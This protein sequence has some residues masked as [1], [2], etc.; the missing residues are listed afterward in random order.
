MSDQQVSAGE[1]EARRWLASLRS[2][3]ERV[4]G[5]LEA[6]SVRELV[7]IH[8][9]GVLAMAV[10]ASTRYGALA[11]LA[12]LAFAGVAL[13]PSRTLRKRSRKPAARPAVVLAV[14]AM[15]LV[16]AL[17]M[18]AAWLTAVPDTVGFAGFVL[19]YFSAGQ[20][21]F[22]WR[23]AGGPPHRAPLVLAG[24]VG[25]ALVGLAIVRWPEAPVGFA[26]IAAGVA[27][28]PV[29]IALLAEDTRSH[30]LRQRAEVPYVGAVL[31]ILGAAVGLLLGASPVVVLPGAVL[32]GL[33]VAAITSNTTL[34]ITLLV[35]AGALVWAF[36]PTD[37]RDLEV[38]DPRPGDRVLI[39]LGDSYLSGEG[40][41]RYFQGTNVRGTNECRRSP[42]AHPVLLAPEGGRVLFPAC[43]GAVGRDVHGA[44][45][46]GRAIDAA[47]NPAGYARSW[48][49]QVDFA[50]A[51]VD[52]LDL[53]PVAIVVSV[54]GND[55]GF[56]RI[57]VTCGLPGDCSE[58]GD[59]WLDG[60]ADVDAVLHETYAGIAQ[61]AADL[62]GVPVVVVP[63]PVPIDEVGCGWSVLTRD[64]HR[65]LAGFTRQLNR[66]VERNARAWGFHV[67]DEAASVLGD[68]GLR[69]CDGPPREMG[70]N[71]IAANPVT[72]AFT[73]QLSP[74]TWFRNSFHPNARGHA[75]LRDVI[76][77]VL[78]EAIDERRAPGPPPPSGTT[79]ELASVEELVRDGFAHC[80]RTDRRPTTCRPTPGAWTVA[81]VARTLVL[82]SVPSALIA[83]G[84][85]VVSIWLLDRRR[86]ARARARD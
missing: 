46:T 63:Y 49:S 23:A 56:A 2:A 8:V 55:A 33:L 29:G 68:R 75:A 3:R 15:G 31:L 44:E 16:G 74:L 77:P 70:I 86:L 71:A 18:G 82:A 85:W 64:E 25:T 39:A 9:L 30:P 69:L 80:G 43:S 40:A 7:L 26:L 35:L 78:A 58:L 20:L 81:Q 76:A 21:V 5:F 66:V 28:V 65:F 4:R 42:D 79:T 53:E 36:L 38:V 50:R 37:V 67:A 72:G 45:T 22:A 61:L 1:D 73:E 51:A 6:R 19:V 59:V 32:L 14:A 60:L 47:T 24:S 84:A 27:F 34:D 11:R 41:T 57:G 13:V 12:T 54:G 48:G 17:A 10:S 83:A 62:G 52:Q